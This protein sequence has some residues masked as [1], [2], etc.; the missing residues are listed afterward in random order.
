MKSENPFHVN[1]WFHGDGKHGYS[2]C[3]Q[4]DERRSRR[5]MKGSDMRA[6]TPSLLP[7]SA[8]RGQCQLAL[9]QE[10]VAS[11]LIWLVWQ[12]KLREPSGVP[13]VPLS[14]GSVYGYSYAN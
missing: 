3:K 8:T 5:E 10:S 6:N 2:A 1:R 9:W 12:E 14:V 11:G 4:D 7:P 13:A